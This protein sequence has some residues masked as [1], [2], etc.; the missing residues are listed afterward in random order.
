MR[1]P[2]HIVCASVHLTGARCSH[3]PR[4]AGHVSAGAGGGTEQLGDISSG[5]RLRPL[6]AFAVKSTSNAG[7][8]AGCAGRGT[9]SHDTRE[10][11]LDLLPT[12]SVTA[13]DAR[14]RQQGLSLLERKRAER[15]THRRA[16]DCPSS[17]SG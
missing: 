1:G 6:F 5:A 7:G 9:S 8:K 4:P 11:L 17:A 13:G 16:P 10:S 3:S 12:C 15:P 14:R 2:R